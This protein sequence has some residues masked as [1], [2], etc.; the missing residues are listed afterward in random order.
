MPELNNTGPSSEPPAGPLSQQNH[1]LE[2]AMNLDQISQQQR[3]PKPDVADM[4]QTYMQVR[5]DWNGKSVF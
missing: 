4:V 5:Q 1:P 2:G 3:K